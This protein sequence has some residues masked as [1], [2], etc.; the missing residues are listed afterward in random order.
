MAAQKTSAPSANA[1]AGREIAVQAS[2]STT[3]SPEA[4]WEVLSRLRTH[5][6]WGSGSDPKRGRLHSIDAPAEPAGV[7]TEFTSTGED[8]MCRM[9]DRSVVTEAT[10]PRVL[11]FVTESAMELKK[12]GARADWTIVHRY[13]I[14]PTGSGS[15]ITHAYRVTRASDLPGPL[16][17]LQIPLLRSFVMKEFGGEMERG[18]AELVAAVEAR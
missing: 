3:A 13:E 9:R 6:E 16:K 7:G 17:M 11:E 18:L 12:G 5:G 10:G 15:S 1:L 2:R 14:E 4:V 8:R